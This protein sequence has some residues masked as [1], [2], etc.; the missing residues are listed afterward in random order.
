MGQVALLHKST[1]STR[2]WLAKGNKCLACSSQKEVFEQDTEAEAADRKGQCDS[3][4]TG[5]GTD[6]DKVW[7]FRESTWSPLLTS[8]MEWTECDMF[9]EE[10]TDFILSYQAS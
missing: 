5:Q 4:R 8:E 3:A 6:S 10:G 7:M 2:S 9:G 1:D